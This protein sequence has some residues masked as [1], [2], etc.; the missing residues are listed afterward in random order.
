MIVCY[1]RRHEYDDDDDDKD[2][3]NLVEKLR[4]MQVATG[5]EAIFGRD[6]SV[7]TRACIVC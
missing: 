2:V 4:F 7:L 3:A 1:R 5:A 6:V